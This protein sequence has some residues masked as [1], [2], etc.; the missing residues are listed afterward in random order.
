MAS[1][2]SSVVNSTVQGA[3]AGAAGG[4]W[5]AAIGGGV[6]LIGGL[7]GQDNERKRAAAAEEAAKKNQALW[8]A[9]VNPNQTVNYENM[10]VGPNV[11]PR[12]ATAQ[13][14]SAHDNLQDINLDPRLAN[15]KMQSL[16]TL[17]KIAG[18]GFTPEELNALQK[19]QSSQGADL[20][21][22]LKQIQ[23]QQDMRGV[24]NSDMA[25]SQRMMEA[26]GSAN[27]GAQAARDLQAQ[28][29]RRSLDAITQGGNLANSYENTEYARGQNLA[30]SQN[31]RD[32]QNF[33]EAS[34]TNASNV[35][36]FNRALESNVGRAR[37]VGDSNTA[38][39]NSQQ[40][41]NNTLGQQHFNRG[42]TKI[43]GSQGVNNS[44]A[45]NAATGAANSNQM[46]GGVLQ[47][48]GQAG[49]AALSS[50]KQNGSPSDTMQSLSDNYKNKKLYKTDD[51]A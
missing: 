12:L 26:Q 2:N 28:G 31:A 40:D 35:D 50:N 44:E 10:Q 36:R 33:S 6:G 4:P 11:D 47:G 3:G 8:D 34:R 29:L 16:E 13:T 7:I 20:T 48:L 41:Q 18:S 9:L 21:S 5:G 23:Q 37:T 24:G 19:Q 51:I 43:T 38:I 22:K 30:N 42:V 15:A 14:M 17:Q 27:S 32:L 45:A 39:R 49:A 1:D 46:W 25:M